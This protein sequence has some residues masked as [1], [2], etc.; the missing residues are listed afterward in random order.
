MKLKE[1]EIKVY[2]RAITYYAIFENSKG[3]TNTCIIENDE[4]DKLLKTKIKKHEFI[5]K[6][7]KDKRIKSRLIFN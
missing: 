1:I 7:F 2:Y 6:T 3:E 4:I 5:I